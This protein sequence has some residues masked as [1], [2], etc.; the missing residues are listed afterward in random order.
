MD[1]GFVQCQLKPA[2]FDQ[3]EFNEIRRIPESLPASDFFADEPGFLRGRSFPGVIGV[4]PD[5]EVEAA[6]GVL[7][8]AENIGKVIQTLR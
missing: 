2:A 4:V 1:R 7:R 5:R 3:L 8:R 6:H